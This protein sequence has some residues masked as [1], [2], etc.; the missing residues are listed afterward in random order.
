MLKERYLHPDDRPSDVSTMLPKPKPAKRAPRPWARKDV[1]T[2]PVECRAWCAQIVA[3]YA[4]GEVF[5]YPPR[6]SNVYKSRGE[7][8]VVEHGPLDEKD[9]LKA[10]CDG[11]ALP[12]VPRKD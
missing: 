10:G 6:G 12:L 2:D 11:P 9:W 5:Y 8:V 1:P 7:L 3:G 4:D